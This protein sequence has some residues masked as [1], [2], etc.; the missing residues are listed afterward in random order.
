MKRI[1]YYIRKTKYRIVEVNGRFVV[2]IWVADYWIELTSFGTQ[3][4]AKTYIESANNSKR[5][6][7]KV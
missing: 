6:E 1:N 3:D 2:S 4:K 5:K 7:E